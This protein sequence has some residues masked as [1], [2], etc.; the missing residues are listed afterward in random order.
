M[1][2]L[3]CETS[4]CCR[5]H[6]I[7][8]MQ[9]SSACSKAA[10]E[11]CARALQAA[12]SKPSHLTAIARLARRKSITIS[13]LGEAKEGPAW[14][15]MWTSAVEHSKLDQRLR[16]YR[17]AELARMFDAWH[18]DSAPLMS[19]VLGKQNFLLTPRSEPPNYSPTTDSPSTVR[20]RGQEVPIED[21]VP[22]A[23]IPKFDPRATALRWMVT[24]EMKLSV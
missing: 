5:S 20:F 15:A 19:S 11:D 10:G 13:L 16:R 8:P 9:L 18:W 4:S 22:S 7:T 12:S 23:P 21:A 3:T 1:G 6:R 24:E 14:V 17:T 2:A